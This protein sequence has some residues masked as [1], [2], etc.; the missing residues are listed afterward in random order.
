M[1]SA[2]MLAALNEQINEEL[3]SSYIYRSMAAWTINW[4]NVNP[5]RTSMLYGG[6]GA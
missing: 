2:K 4:P 3:A 6:R 5:N 1:L